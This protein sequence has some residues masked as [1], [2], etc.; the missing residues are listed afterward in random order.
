ML[1]SLFSLFSHDLGIDLGTAN[2]LV[3]VKGKGIAIREPS[4]VARHTKTKKI[5]AVGSEAKKMLGK[6]PA[7]ISAIRP[8]E[9][10]VVSD[11]DA[12][13]YLI[14]YHVRK[15]H[16]IGTPFPALA[17]PKVVVGIPSGVTEVER[18]AVWEATLQAGAREC[19]LIEE[20]MAAAIGAGVSVFEPTGVL[21]VDIGGGTCEIAVISLGGIVVNR[22]LKLAGYEMDQAIVHYIRLR[23]GLLIG[24]RTAEDIKVKIGSAY[25]KNSKL[26]PALAGQNSKLKNKKGEDKE[27]NS[28]AQDGSLEP[29]ERGERVALVRGRDI[30]TGLPRSLRVTETEA[31]EA[32]A[33]VVSSIVETI[34]E[35][36]EET[37]PELT[38]DI[39]E[40]GILLTGGGALLSGLDDLIMERTKIPVNIIED[41]LTTVVRGTARL[42]EDKT[43]LDRVKVT[44]GL[45]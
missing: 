10:G 30:E 34:M 25:K 14:S 9:H 16:E 29:E 43:L 17:R 4:L 31:R 42:L 37:P 39:L 21:V 6:T 18:R 5:I 36:V 40:R 24:E 23:H 35:V 41:P 13:S 12:A 1:D 27:R 2:T 33:P 22:S 32:I 20:P 3:Y 44:G 8:L 28:T 38:S 45:R 26:N 19:Y 11:F 7:T 15:V